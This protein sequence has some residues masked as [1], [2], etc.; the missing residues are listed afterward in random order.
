MTATRLDTIVLVSF[1]VLAVPQLSVSTGATAVLDL[2]PFTWLHRGVQRTMD[3]EPKPTQCQ[4]SAPPPATELQ[5]VWGV[6]CRTLPSLTRPIALGLGVALVTSAALAGDAADKSAAELIEHLKAEAAHQQVRQSHVAQAIE[7]AEA[8][9]AQARAVKANPTVASTYEDAAR[10]WASV[11]IDW[12]QVSQREAEAAKIEESVAEMRRELKHQRALLEETA[13]RKGR[14]EGLIKKLKA[15]PTDP[16]SVP[17][18]VSTSP[19]SATQ[20]TGDGEPKP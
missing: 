7:R 11:G 10:E 9:L 20:A 12:Q 17:P 13:A 5:R 15:G 18:P 2:G 3:V 19:P 1:L 4:S 14:A 8:A 6:T 16:D